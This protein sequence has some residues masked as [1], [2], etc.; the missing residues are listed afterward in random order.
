MPF[1]EIIYE[2]GEHSIAENVGDDGALSGIKE[3]HRRAV[4]G[5]LGGPAGQPA[6][7]IKRVLV[8]DMHPASFTPL[9]TTDDAAAAVAS[10]ATGD[11]IDV[12]VAAQVV[13]GLRSPVVVSEPHESNYK[14]TPNRE[15][16]A[17]AWEDN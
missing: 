16:A 9:V 3:Q 10:V 14:M 7:R 2:N 15:L 13:R 1:Y 8:F 5:E 17:S 4:S 6:Q 12:E 11:L